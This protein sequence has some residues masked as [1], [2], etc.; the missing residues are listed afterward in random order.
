MI[1]IFF[2]ITG[3][4]P[5]FINQ[6]LGIRDNEI[7]VL[8]KSAWLMSMVAFIWTSVPFLVALA[9]FA[10]YVFMDEGNTLDATR[11]F[12]TMSYLVSFHLFYGQCHKKVFKVTIL[13]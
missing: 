1:D 8:K 6:V 4:E 2:L 5:S 7:V 10:T 9:S 11:T 13:Y 3:W 12:V